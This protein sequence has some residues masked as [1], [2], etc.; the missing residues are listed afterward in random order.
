MMTEKVR[1][2]GI[3]VLSPHPENRE[4]V[5]SGEDW[6]DFKRSVKRH[7]VLTPLLIRPH[8]GAFQIVCGERR[9]Q[10]ATAL[11]MAAV[12]C[13]VRELSDEAALELMMVENLQREDVDPVEEARGVRLLIEKAGLSAEEVGERICKSAD[14]VNLRQGLLSLPEEA[15]VRARSREVSLGVLQMVLHLPEQNREEG[16]QMVLHPAFQD[17]PLNVRQAEQ[18][19]NEEI[20]EPA[21]R[22]AEWEERKGVLRT[23]WMVRLRELVSL[24]DDRGDLVVQVAEWDERGKGQCAEDKVYAVDLTPEAP[25]PLRW[26]SLA[27]RHGLPVRVFPGRVDQGDEALNDSVAMVDDQLIMAG[28]RALEENEEG[29]A[30]YGPARAESKRRESGDGRQEEDEREDEEEAQREEVRLSR[31]TKMGAEMSGWIDVKKVKR[32]VDILRFPC[33]A[34]DIAFEDL[35]AWFSA[36]WLGFNDEERKAAREALQWVLESCGGEVEQ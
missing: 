3:E 20:I 11:E 12:P 29:A 21:R 31:E 26:L 4:I 28:E 35:P 16:L 14:W 15:Q 17:E 36:H 10:A 24:P 6:E 9:W 22:R 13:V 7:G 23:R 30:W 1:E 27:L 34:D 2:Y 18:L 19:L 8:E 25:Q 32:A 33:G 5:T